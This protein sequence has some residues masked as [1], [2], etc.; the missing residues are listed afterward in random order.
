[1]GHG[2]GETVATTTKAGNVLTLVA[3]TAYAHATLVSVK[4]ADICEFAAINA[5]AGTDVCTAPFAFVGS[6]EEMLVFVKYNLNLNYDATSKPQVSIAATCT[7]AANSGIGSSGLFGID[8]IQWYQTSADTSLV[9]ATVGTALLTWDQPTGPKTVPDP[10]TCVHRHRQQPGAV[11]VPVLR[12]AP[13]ARGT[14]ASTCSRS[15]AGR[16]PPAATPLSLD[17]GGSDARLRHRRPSPPLLACRAGRSSPGGTRS[18]PEGGL[19]LPALP[20][21]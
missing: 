13:V 8:P 16:G 21:G 20:A 14:G 7:N 12:V 6:T 1:V 11:G 3:P 18:R 2:E 4:N 17:R 10:I 15:R 9:N 19:P 5:G